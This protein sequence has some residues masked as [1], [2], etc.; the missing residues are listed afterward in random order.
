MPEQSWI[1]LSVAGTCMLHSISG[2]IYQDTAEGTG[3][4]RKHRQGKQQE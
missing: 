2:C 4:A 3:Q 1:S